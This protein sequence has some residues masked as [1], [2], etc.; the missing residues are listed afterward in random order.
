MNKL[1]ATTLLS[2]LTLALWAS[3]ASAG[4]L[5]GTGCCRKC[6]QPCCCCQYNAFS[7]FCCDCV[8]CGKGCRK[9]CYPAAS[10]CP[11]PCCPPACCTDPCCEGGLGHL[12]P[13][14]HAP[15]P[16]PPPAGG[17]SQTF[18]PPGPAPLP[19]EPSTR[20]YGPA[21]L[22]YP[23]VQSVGYQAGHAP[24]YHPGYA[25]APAGMAPTGGVPWYWNAGR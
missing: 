19:M 9:C 7:P 18:A 13:D 14:Q 6:C 22:P 15:P 24:A 21:P 10:C 3:Q 23:P 1:L 17:Q 12:P 4:Y 20:Q 11:P 2:A 25:P 16:S 5:R 8:S